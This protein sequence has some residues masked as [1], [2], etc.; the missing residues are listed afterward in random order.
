MGLTTELRLAL[1][2]AFNNVVFNTIGV[3]STDTPAHFDYQALPFAARLDL[4]WAAP[5]L[6]IEVRGGVSTRSRV[7]VTFPATADPSFT[8]AEAVRYAGVLGEIVVHP[9][10]GLAVY[11]TTARA[12]T[13]RRSVTGVAEEF[14]LLEET[15]GLGTRARLAG[16]GILSFELDAHLLSR[17]EIRE[18]G[19]DSA[20]RHRD[21][22]FFLQGALLHRPSSGWLW[23]LG[24]A[25][26]DRRAGVLAPQLTSAN[27]RQI[28]EGGHR[29]R[30]GFEVSA[31]VRWDVDAFRASAFDGGHLRLSTTW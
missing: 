4:A 17:P 10:I 24:L 14:D 2:D 25:F 21:R 13:Q 12:I 9:R 30:T 27:V 22:E 26:L 19:V 31:G 1:L 5:H 16:A 18:S 7:L 8:Q 11:G 3:A 20:V 15:N 23:R 28:M 6:R 29:F